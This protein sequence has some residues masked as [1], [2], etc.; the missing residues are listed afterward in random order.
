M[1]DGVLTLDAK[2]VVTYVNP[3][4]SRALG[5]VA[6]ELVGQAA[7]ATFHRAHPDG[8]LYSP[9]ESPIHATL[10]DGTVHHVR[11]GEVFWRKDGKSIPVEYVSIPLRGAVSKLEGVMVTFRSTSDRERTE[12]AL[13]ESEDRF[14]RL[15]EAAL[16]GVLIHDNGKIIDANDAIAGIL[17]YT[18]DELIGKNF[19]DHLAPDSRAALRARLLAGTE[20][21]FAA[22]ALRRDGSTFPVEI[23]GKS[24]PYEG[25]TVRVAAIRE[26]TA[27][28]GASDARRILDLYERLPDAFFALDKNWRFTYLN[29]VAL[30]MVPPQHRARR[31]GEDMWATFPDLKGTKFDTEYHR[32]MSEQVPVH[33][34]E[35]FARLG[36]WFS[37]DAYPSPDGLSIFFRDVTERRR[38]EEATRA[39]NVSRTL[40][41][42]IVQ[43]L[44]ESGS[45][46]HPTLQQVGRKLASE[47]DE[48]DL[49]GFIDAY[50]GMGLG[51]LR[52]DRSEEGR[53]TFVGADLLERRVGSR[54]ATC[55]FTLGFLS[56]AV[57]RVSRGEPTLGTEIDC[58]SR[59]SHECRF[60]VQVK[61]PEEG[62]ARRV[63]E[64]V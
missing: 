33:V 61:K 16:E 8:T 3:A 11:G 4:A 62:L 7:L 47:T 35:Y 56:E 57:S 50:M 49:A 63:K 26:A 2:G 46:P 28:G 10:A 6:G 40:V 36:R 30:A 43:D 44:V 53:F 24:I 29:P 20:G 60:V 45:V 37:A 17:G 64:L 15:S 52:V 54:V 38:L 13:R 27:T 1:S 19:L 41:R 25:R 32:A 48:D 18:R 5:Y 39:S 55:F 22:T 34:E 51:S 42:R 21:L 58:Q 59:G 31:I 23:S 14:R 12:R 9:D